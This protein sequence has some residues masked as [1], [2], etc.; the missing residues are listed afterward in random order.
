[1]EH[2]IE[3]LNISK[4]FA[5]QQVLQELCL[6]VERGQPVGIVGPNGSGKSVLFQILC[7][8]LRPDSGSMRIA[9]QTLEQGRDFPENLGMLINA[10]GFIALETGLKNLQ[11]L[12]GIRNKIGDDEIRETM[13]KVGLDPENRT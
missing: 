7:G 10:P 3:M 4:H 11:Y 8:L 9:G 5:H 12:A 1:M 13:R 2:N 6:T